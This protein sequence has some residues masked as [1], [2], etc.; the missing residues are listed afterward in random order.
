MTEKGIG[1][2][3]FCCSKE[4][5]FSRVCGKCRRELELWSH[6]HFASIEIEVPPHEIKPMTKS[7]IERW[8]QWF[9]TMDGGGGSYGHDRQLAIDTICDAALVG[10][11]I[12]KGHKRLYN[13]TIARVLRELADNMERGE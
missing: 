13:A 12:V 10:M 3:R 11:K 6:D 7:A 1:K 9:K 5:V 8:R 4:S 2:C